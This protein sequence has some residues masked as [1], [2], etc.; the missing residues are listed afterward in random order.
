[1][2]DIAFTIATAYILGAIPFGYILFRLKSGDDIRKYG[3]GNIG[4]TNMLRTQGKAMGIITMFLDAGKGSL[5]VCIPLFLGLDM[6][7]ASICGV[8]AVAGHM[9]PVFLGF[10]GGKGVATAAGVFIVLAPLAFALGLV[11]FVGLIAV[12]R[13]VS[14]GSMISAISIPVIMLV[15]KAAGRGMDLFLVSAAAVIALLII[16]R[17]ASNIANLAA[18]KEKKFGLKPEMEKKHE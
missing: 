12:T 15:F 16:I 17:H 6:K 3:S 18:G 5:A 14:L 7:W 1:M 11:I 4:A 2:T 13:Y 8:A 10:R 9:F